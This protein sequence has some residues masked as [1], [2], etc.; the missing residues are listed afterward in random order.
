MPKVLV[1]ADHIA[2]Q[3]AAGE[4][5]ERP[6]SVVKELVENALDSGATQIEIS[7]SADCRDIR[8]ADN[9]CGMEIE[10]AVL[11]FHRHATSKLKNVEDLWNLNSLGFRGEALPSIASVARVTCLTRTHD[12]AE[13]S[14]IE[15][16]DGKVTTSQTGCAPGTVMEVQDLFYNVPARLS[17]LKRASTEFGHIHEIVQSLAIAYPQVAI[18]LIHQGQSSFRTTGSGDLSLA[19]KEAGLFSGREQLCE[20][21]AG[22]RDLG[23]SI[24]G[25]VAKPLHFRGDRKG[26]LSI[27]NNRPVRCPLTYKALDYAY[28]DLIPRGRHPFAVVVV[29]VNPTNLDVNIHPTKKEIKYSNG[30]EVY[31][32]IQRALMAALRQAKSEAREAEV[33]R[34]REE[35]HYQVSLARDLQSTAFSGDEQQAEDQAAS[36]QT[37]QNEHANSVSAIMHEVSDART[38]A[39]SIGAR[40]TRQLGFKDRLQYA[41]RLYAPV[42]GET[43]SPVDGRAYHGPGTDDESPESASEYGLA[44]GAKLSPESGQ[45][46]TQYTYSLPHGW[47]IAAYIHNTYIILE[48]PEGMEIVEQ[49]IAHER[50]LYERLLAQQTVAGRTTECAQRLLVSTPLQL[51]MEQSNTLRNNIEI[52]RKLGF[53]F[54]CSDDHVTCT[55]V[56]LE[57]AHKDYACVVQELAQQ[58]AI[59]DGADLELEA[60]KSIA[61]QSAIKNGMPMSE[62]DLVQLLC[63]WDATPRNDTCPHGRPVRLKFSMEKLFQMFHPA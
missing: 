13:G 36:L 54:E 17:F 35:F 18:N 42:D 25:Y 49:H 60:T 62:R 4:V 44:S 23:L 34:E 56:P 15:A 55:Q 8:I 43:S 50:T 41:T 40:A 47:R 45:L 24:R 48:T 12:S 52:L 61:C 22:D 38:V 31:I 39:E 16:A 3:I 30:N 1:L 5:V 59:A 11:A 58:L 63:E 46:P 6:S 20:V 37:A 14:K 32:A 27:V 9:G 29:D 53:D 19:V 26:I 10:D 2:S 57:L 33:A 51:S 21:K 28:S 7:I